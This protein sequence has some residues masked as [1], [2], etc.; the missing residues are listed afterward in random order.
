MY[1]LCSGVLAKDTDSKVIEKKS[2]ALNLI[3]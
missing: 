3:E 2:S 1:A